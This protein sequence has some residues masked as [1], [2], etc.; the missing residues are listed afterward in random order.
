MCLFG[1]R[2]CPAAPP[3]LPALSAA[4]LPS[5]L[6]PLP[7]LS[8]PQALSDFEL[9]LLFSLDWAVARLLRKHQLLC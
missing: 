7:F 9:D 8:S 4:R 3:P 5:R 1:R 6:S 2:R